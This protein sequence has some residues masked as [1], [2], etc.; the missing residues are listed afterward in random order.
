M[1]LNNNSSIIRKFLNN[2][3]NITL[4]FYVFRNTKNMDNKYQAREINISSDLKNFLKENLLRSLK[5]LQTDQKFHAV[6]Y[7]S[8]FE[9]H[10]NLSYLK[11]NEIK[12]VKNNFKAMKLAMGENE[13]NIKYASYQF[14]KLIDDTNNKASYICF[15]QGNRG[16]GT[17]K[18]LVFKRE[19]FDLVDEDLITVGGDLDFIISEDEKIYIKS[20]RP[21]EWAFQYTDHINRMRDENIK[22]ILNQEVFS[23]DFGKNYFKSEAEKYIRSRSIAQ[24]KDDTLKNLKTHFEKRCDDLMI[25]KKEFEDKQADN[26]ELISKYGILIDLL[27]FIDFENKKI[28]INDAN[29]SN[30]NPIFH[31]FQNK[32]VESFLTKEI[33]TA[34]GFHEKGD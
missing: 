26:K 10:D 23:N 6:K 31:L 19:T 24:M 9:V 15:Y 12:T 5:E 32:I 3:S 30:I 17:N 18:R 1:Y 2:S 21:F 27:D 33:Q 28:V 22:K 7:N 20:I 13:L 34:V 25:I 29:K 4:E 8:E 14:L 11:I 16:A